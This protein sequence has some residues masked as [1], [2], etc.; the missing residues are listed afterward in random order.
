MQKIG[1]FQRAENKSKRKEIIDM[2]GKEIREE[3]DSE[4]K[5]KNKIVNN[6]TK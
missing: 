6:V 3:T 5:K 2:N 4:K 1:N